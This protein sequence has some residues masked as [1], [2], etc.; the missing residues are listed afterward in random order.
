MTETGFVDIH[1]HII[2]E[3]DDGS[4]SMDRS[5]EMIR[6]AYEEGVRVLFATPHFGIRNP[7]YDREKAERNF[8]ELQKR[9]GEEFP[10]MELRYGA[11]LYCGPGML[12]GLADGSAGQMSESGHAMLEFSGRADFE[13]I[14]HGCRTLIR[15]GYQPILAHAER[16]RNAFRKSSEVAE[17]CAQGVLM[18]MNTASVLKQEELFDAMPELKASYDEASFLERGLMRKSA[19]EQ[20]KFCCRLITEGLVTFMGT[21]CHDMA[22]RRPVVLRPYRAV[23]ELVGE[24]AAEELFR[25]NAARVLGEAEQSTASQ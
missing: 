10:D 7:G 8:K 25:L 24:P 17:L 2:P 12:S 5:V 23:T 9:T 19:R 4:A 1:A 18:Q 15:E 21:D 14:F 13:E 6:L 20:W 16:Y 3:I 22:G 11:E